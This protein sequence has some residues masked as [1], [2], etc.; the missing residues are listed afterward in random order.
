MVNKTKIKR[1]P[2]IVFNDFLKLPIVIIG[3]LCA[4][5]RQNSDFLGFFAKPE[6]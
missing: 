1:Q 6:G 3:W 5:Y 4:F 2:E